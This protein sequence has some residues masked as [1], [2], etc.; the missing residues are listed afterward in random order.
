MKKYELT[1]ETRVLN[2]GVT[3]RRIKA[4]RNFGNVNK[5]TLGGWVQSEDNLS[6]FGNA[7]ISGDSVVCHDAKVS[8]N[9]IVRLSSW[10]DDN[11]HIY[12]DA[13]VIGG[14]VHDN[15]Q[16]FDEAK[17]SGRIFDNVKIYGMAFVDSCVTIMD[18]VHI[19]GN[20]EIK[21]GVTMMDEPTISG[22]VKIYGNAVVCGD[23]HLSG[24]KRI[25]GNVVYRKNHSLYND[26]YDYGDNEPGF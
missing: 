19:F 21:G 22:N 24:N 10:V 12:G 26:G 11:A 13:K 8:D 7:W 14:R 4:I 20:A 23:V 2:D 17:V 16:V 3:L 5:G 6:H 15:V 9:A 18:N 25:T 1:S